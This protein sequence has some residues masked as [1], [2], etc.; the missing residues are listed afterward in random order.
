MSCEYKC[1][2][3][4]GGAEARGMGSGAGVRR[5]HANVSQRKRND[6]SRTNKSLPSIFKSSAMSVVWERNLETHATL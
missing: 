5:T 3:S 1:F 6:L 2:Q 4:S